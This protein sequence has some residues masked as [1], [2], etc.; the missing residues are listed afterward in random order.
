M[1]HF[2]SV[3]NIKNLHFQE[4]QAIFEPPKQEVKRFSEDSEAE[5]F[6]HVLSMAKVS[7]KDISL[8]VGN[9]SKL[10]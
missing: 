7:S 3:L 5:G 1:P 9:V 4:F 8:S 10:L 6:R 2:I